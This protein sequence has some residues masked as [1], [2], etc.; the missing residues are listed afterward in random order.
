[1]QP[2][3]DPENMD[4]RR[5]PLPSFSPDDFLGRTFLMEP[6]DNGERH[7]ARISRIIYDSPESDDAEDPKQDVVKFL[8]SI[9]GKEAD[10]IVA[11]N[12]I[13]DYLERQEQEES[14]G[15]QLWKFREIT[16]HQGPLAKTDKDY[17]G[18]KW[19][20]L[21]EWETGECTYE[22][23][24]VI[25][26]D[27]P[28]TCAVYA[29]RNGLLDTPGWKQFRGIAKRHKR[30]IR[31]VKQSQL[32]Q[33]RR[34]PIYKFGFRVPR[35]HKEAVEIDTINGNTRWQDAERLELAQID[36]Y[37]TFKD[38]GRAVYNE[39]GHVQNTPGPD[40]KRIRV[41]MV[42]DVKHDGRHK[43]R[44]V[45]DGNLT[46]VPV[47][48]VYSGVV[49]LRGLRMVTF[50][51]QLNDLELWGADVGNAY[52]ESKTK[53][54]IFI[55]AGPEF[56]Q[57]Q[58]HVLS[59][60][61]SL[62]GLRTSGKRWHERFADTLQDLGFK[63]SKADSDIWMR[64][65]GKVWEYIAVYVDDL[66]IAMKNPQEFIDRLTNDYKYKLKGTGPIKY[67]LGLDY[68]TDPDGTLCTTP[69]KYIGKMMSSYQNM[70]GELPR[71]YSSPLEQN[72]HPELDQS[73]ECGAEDARKYLHMIGSLQWLIS[74]GRF[75]IYPATMTMGRFRLQPRVK[76]LDRLKRMYGYVKKTKDGTVR[77]R[78]EEPDYSSLPEQG[79]NWSHSIYGD[80]KEDLPRDMP[81]AL[82]KRVV[83]T[84]YVDANLMHDLITGRSVTAVLHLIN[85]TPFEWYSKRQ[86]TVET[87]TF[88]SEF[89]AARTAVDQ[90]IDI[91][92]SLRYLGVPVHAKTFMF[93][94]NESVVKN[95]TLPHSTLNKRH[96]A[97]SYHR[98]REAIAA[99]IVGFYHTRSETNP[100]DL[101]S[102]HW[103][104]V[105]AWPLLRAML[106]W[107]GDTSLAPK[108]VGPTKEEKKQDILPHERTK[109]ECYRIPQNGDSVEN[110]VPR[111]IGTEAFLLEQRSSR[112]N[113]VGPTSVS[114]SYI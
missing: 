27:D 110:L 11:Y 93:G 13:L 30:M 57:R 102:K 49:S 9:E 28:V 20:V 60:H 89:V 41:H 64:K 99:K 79:D 39:K 3:S 74:L 105:K 75:D 34:S 78:T 103:S 50:L 5:P 29:K 37:D 101:L 104:F 90:I 33:S 10:E 70:F 25:A 35:S 95:A 18:S 68:H 77:I 71:E 114:M 31:M 7:R 82:G 65:A 52:L 58:G 1:L 113:H 85:K 63:P 94:D 46:Q 84:T 87:A 22:P 108:H 91:R 53:E 61:K 97:L 8:L 47:E 38:H 24:D 26:S 12:D 109:G 16:A 51:S 69:A 17:K 2:L 6:Q 48:A 40:Y 88:G 42:Y 112:S 32:K 55:V 86:A 67:H 4:S 98:V 96:V 92:T 21:V 107:K 14:E 81:E 56:G 23:L 72:D 43:A 59:I 15:D 66:A 80:V 106:F 73:K 19:N 100:A 45:A 83:L 111:D 36:E 44:L 62:Y 76:H 54:K